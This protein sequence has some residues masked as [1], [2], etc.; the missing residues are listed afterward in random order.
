MAFPPGFLDEL[1]SRDVAGRAGRAAGEADPPRPRIWRALPVPQREDAVLLRRRGQGLLSLL[2]L[3]RAWRRDRLCHARRQSRLSSRRSSGWP[4][5]PGSRCRSR[6]R[7]SA[8]GRSARRRC[9]RRSQAAAGSTRAQLW[10]PPGARGARLSRAARP[11]RRDDPPLPPR[12]GAGRPAGAAPRAGRRL[13]RGAAAR[14]RAAARARTAAASRYDYFRDRVMFPIGDRAGRVIAFG[15]RTM[16]DGQPKYLNSPDTPLFEKGRVLYGWALARANVGARGRSGGH[17]VIVAEGYMD[18]IALHRAGFATAVA[19]LGTALTE[20]QLAGTVAA[21]ARAGAVLRRRHRRPAR[22]AARARPRAAAACSRA[23]ACAL[24]PCRAGE[25]PDSLI[26][27]RGAAGVRRDARRRAAAAEMLWQVETGAEPARHAG[28]PRRL[29]SRLDGA[30]RQIADRT[31]QREYRRFL[32]DRL[33]S[34]RPRPAERGA[35]SR[36]ARR[37]RRRLRLGARPAPPPP[38]TRRAGAIARSFSACWSRHP[39]LIDEWI[40]EIG[41]ARFARAGA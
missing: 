39:A 11:R 9:S 12:L 3:R 21:V 7:R 36:P 37:R 20:T 4:A 2:R 40:E 8:S 17:G 41:R 34:A 33:F 24:P 18:V 13:S 16:G 5:R 38:A 29:E 30:G 6:R 28:A 23:T 1:R 22:R 15:G 25:D 14:G 32:R 35:Y 10:S 26:R 27:A 31:V 19:P